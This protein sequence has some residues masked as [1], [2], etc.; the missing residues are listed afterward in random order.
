MLA[1]ILITGG[2][3]QKRQEKALLKATDFLGD[4][5]ENNPD[6]YL[7]KEETSIKI[8]QIRE[9][10]G[11]VSLKPFSAKAI[12]VV[13]SE[14]DKMT[15]PA[16][17][18]L[19]KI[20][21]EPPQSSRIILTAPGPKTLLPTIVSRCQIIHLSD[22]TKIGQ[23]ILNSQ[24]SI[25]N[26]LLSAS[27]GQKILLVEKYSW[28]REQTLSFCQNQL[29]FLRELLHQKT[30]NPKSI[31]HQISLN[32]AQIAKM[33]RSL[34]KSLILLKNNVNPRLLIENLLLSYP[35]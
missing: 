16:Q 12:V 3:T 8:A 9:L 25:L 35:I 23:E 24:F 22:E 15:L 1:S 4:K 27:P 20:L 5:T 31:R 10:K 30:Y 6:F 17:N 28:N 13:I 33:M 34:Q 2:D 29:L 11:K 18:S 19:L 26:S 32:T 14:A 7:I 21:E